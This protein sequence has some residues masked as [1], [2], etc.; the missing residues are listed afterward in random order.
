MRILTHPNP[1]LK[2]LAAAVDAYADGELQR[3]VAEMTK[4]M[5][6]A[7]GIGL[8]APQLGVLK[9]VIIWELDDGLN[10][11]CNPRLVEA[12]EET[13]TD[14][15]GCLSVP[16]I[17]VP[18]V[19]PVRVVCEGELIGG[20]TVRIEAD[21]LLAR[22]LQHEVEHCDGIIILDRAAPEERLA[23]IRRYMTGEQD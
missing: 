8:A 22:I 11:L 12:S 13:E 16:R 4:R 9:R 5:R 2:Q 15:E 10:T 21:D 17:S 14:E 6:E 1:A 19:R 7:P 18:I 20:E 3:L 23:A